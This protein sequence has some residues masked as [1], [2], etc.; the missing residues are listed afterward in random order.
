MARSWPSC[1]DAQQRGG[2]SSLKKTITSR[3]LSHPP[4]PVGGRPYPVAAVPPPT[5][6]PS[7]EPDPRLPGP[8]THTHTRVRAAAAGAA[9]CVAGPAR[10][11]AA[12]GR[13]PAPLARAQ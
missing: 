11:R 3:A 5:L 12:G 1:R 13:R 9:G 6:S 2:A 7:R 10:A 4:P 8:Y